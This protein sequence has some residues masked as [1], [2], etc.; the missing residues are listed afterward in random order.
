MSQATSALNALTA[1]GPFRGPS[2]YD[3]HVREFVRE[4]NR[5]GVQLHLI[6]LPRWTAAKLPDL[7]KDSFFDS[8][9]RPVESNIVLHFTLPKDARNWRGKRNVNF[10]MFEASRVPSDWVR[11]NRAHDLVIVPTESSRRAWIASGMDDKHV[12]VCPLGVDA[13]RYSSTVQPLELKLST[14]ELVSRYSVRLLNISELSPRKNLIGLVRAWITA[15]TPT[16]DAVLILKTG[17]WVPG[18][19]QFF[20]QQLDAM[21]LQTGKRL[22]DAA[23]ILFLRRMLGDA[24]MPQLY[25]AATHYVSMSF[26]EG[27][28]LA[29]TEAA[30]T[31]LHLI[32]PDHSAYQSYLDPSTARLIKAHETPVL[33][34]GDPLT[35]ALFL[36]ATWWKPDESEAVRAIRDAIEHREVPAD[37]AQHRIL[38]EFT[39]EKATDRLIEILTEINRPV[40]RWFF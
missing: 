13:S 25:R 18:A 5:R 1:C 6:D 19:Q 16:D 17:A 9:D 2:G 8:L 24:E 23:P 12:R 26:G 31:G 37:S 33:V 30:A 28:D 10:T 27:W 11:C 14:G 29:M 3:H 35:A 38:A 36:G 34:D 39:W 22:D 15:T 4:L 20:N 32:A 40:R 21:L 7:L